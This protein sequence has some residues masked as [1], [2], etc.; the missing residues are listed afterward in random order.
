MANAAQFRVEC[1]APVDHTYG[2]EEVHTFDW[3]EPFDRITTGTTSCSTD[4]LDPNVCSD[5][6]GERSIGANQLEG[7]PLE[8]QREQCVINPERK[9]SLEEMLH[10][11]PLRRKKKP[12]SL[13]KRPLSAYNLYFQSVRAKLNSEGGNKV[14]FHELGKI[15]GKKWKLLPESEHKIYKELAI[16]DTERYRKEMDQHKKMEATTKDK[17][18][19]EKAIN[20]VC[21]EEG[22]QTARPSSHVPPYSSTS[23]LH[24]YGPRPSRNAAPY[25]FYRTERPYTHN[26]GS[27]GGAS[28]RF[29]P[30]CYQPYD[31]VGPIL[32][33]GVPPNRR[34]LPP[35]SE[36]HLP[37]EMGELRPYTVQYTMVTMSREEAK[38]YLDKLKP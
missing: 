14:G 4:E 7:E 19:S 21:R 16:Q 11:A 36:V 8:Q 27:S 25:T 29:H 37:D 12:K 3:T 32:M 9:R 34:M 22:I 1:G 13:P 28:P 26:W 18:I 15:V 33:E 35:G 23:A 24:D 20:S 31:S 17:G 2:E 30:P 10:S 5:N 6:D 38:D